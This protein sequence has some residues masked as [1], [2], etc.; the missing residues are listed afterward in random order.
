MYVVGMANESEEAMALNLTI[1]HN[2]PVYLK[3]SIPMMVVYTVA[4]SAVFFLG[5]CM[6]DVCFLDVTTELSCIQLWRRFGAFLCRRVT[7]KRMKLLTIY[8]VSQKRA[9]L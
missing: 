9:H 1:P 4:Y 5:T 8:T 6:H 3:Q 7:R 2:A